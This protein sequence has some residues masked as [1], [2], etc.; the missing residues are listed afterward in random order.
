MHTSATQP[1][2]MAPRSFRWLQF[3]LRTML[4][5]ILVA[6]LGLGWYSRELRRRERIEKAVQLLAAAPKMTGWDH[7]PV[8]LIRAANA[9]HSLGKKDAIDALRRFAARYPNDC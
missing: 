6:A 3:S 2:V 9:L 7:D 8:A 5:V 1:V 4:L